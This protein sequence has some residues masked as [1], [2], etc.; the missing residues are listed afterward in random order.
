MR[1]AKIFQ[2]HEETYQ[3]QK[4]IIGRDH[5]QCSIHNDFDEI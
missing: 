2:I 1:D 4:L 3:T 5:L